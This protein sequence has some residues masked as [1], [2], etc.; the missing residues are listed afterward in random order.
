MFHIWGLLGRMVHIIG[1]MVLKDIFEVDK[2][3]K[4]VV[5]VI[6]G[7]FLVTSLSRKRGKFL[8]S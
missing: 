8:F 6:N 2:L 1:F 5:G 3:Q 7:H 4:C